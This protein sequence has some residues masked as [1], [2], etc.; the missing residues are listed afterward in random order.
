MYNQETLKRHKLHSRESKTRNDTLRDVHFPE[1]GGHKGWVIQ[2]ERD[3][4]G[5]VESG[6]QLSQDHVAQNLGTVIVILTGVLH[7]TEPIYITYVGFTIR[8]VDGKEQTMK[9]RK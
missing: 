4:P 2:L 7:K 6:C 9:I 3:C 8:S 1:G 5:K